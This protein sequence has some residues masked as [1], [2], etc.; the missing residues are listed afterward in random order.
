MIIIENNTVVENTYAPLSILELYLVARKIRMIKIAQAMN[1][2]IERLYLKML[3]MGQ[4]NR[5]TP[6]AKRN[7]H[8]SLIDRYYNKLMA[9][10]SEFL[11][12]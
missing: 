8:I 1:R 10:Y 5:I 2:Y 6:R 3:R 11:K 12:Q 9:S 7:I 4:L